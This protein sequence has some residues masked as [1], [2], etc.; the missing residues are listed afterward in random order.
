[1]KSVEKQYDACIRNTLENGLEHLGIMSSYAWN[2]DPKRLAFTLSRY[3][4]VSKMFNGFSNVLEV[5]CS[6]GFFTR[7]VVQAV[8]NL[9]AID[10]DPL[11]VKDANERMSDKWKFKCVT[12]DMLSGPVV[13]DF[14]G[15]YLLD[16]LEHIAPRNEDLFIKNI[17]DSLNDSGVCIIGIPSLESQIYASPL[18]KEGHVNCK[19]MPDL[20]EIMEKYFHNV[21]M[22]S[23]NDEVV[24]T[25]FHKMANY[26]FAVCCN[27]R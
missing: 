20:K 24:H 17:V 15:V 12:H 25:G 23:M 22:F 2:D 26:I 13:G 19:T 3:K 5:G 8:Q 1:M 18:S 4:F 7:V 6:D 16:V 9:T 14:D 27:K 11:F 21:F 10:F